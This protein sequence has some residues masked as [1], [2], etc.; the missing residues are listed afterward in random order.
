MSNFSEEQGSPVGPR[1]TLHLQL[2]KISKWEQN[3]FLDIH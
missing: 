2:G 1:I 3:S